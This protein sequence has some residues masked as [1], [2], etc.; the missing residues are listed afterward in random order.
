MAI[1]KL[2][3]ETPWDEI[4]AVSSDIDSSRD[5]HPSFVSEEKNVIHANS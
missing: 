2:R 5:S 3:R 1:L 4:E